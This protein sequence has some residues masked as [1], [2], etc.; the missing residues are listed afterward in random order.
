MNKKQPNQNHMDTKWWDNL[1]ENQKAMIDNSIISDAVYETVIAR[2]GIE[3]DDVS[4]IDMVE[5]VLR[6][7]ALN[8]ILMTLW[9]NIDKEKAIHFKEFS[10]QC[11][12]IRPG[13]PTESILMEFGRMYPELRE[14]VSIA[15][16]NFFH[17][18][19][20]NYKHFSQ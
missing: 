12:V 19:V 18:F 15:L 13:R 7:Q 3:P 17:D 11:M 4:Q 9:R 5:G 10:R 16:G 1:D 2:L 8:V 6:R 14:K 20:K